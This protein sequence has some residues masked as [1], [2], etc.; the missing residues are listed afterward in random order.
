VLS[1]LDVLQRLTFVANT[2]TA[3]LPPGVTIDTVSTTIVVLDPR[4]DAITTRSGAVA[5]AL[6]S[7]PMG[8][9]PA[10]VLRAPGVSHCADWLYDRVALHR[11][12]VSGW[13]G[14]A[15]CGVPQPAHVALTAPEA[16][17]A[18]GTWMRSS[19][20]VGNLTC[21]VLMAAVWGDVVNANAAV[22]QWM[23]YRQP[24][25][26]QAVIDYPRI[27]QGWR[28]FAPHAPEEDFSIE[29]DAVTADGRHVDPYNEVASRTHMIPSTEIAARLHQNQFFTAFS[30]FIWRDHFRAYR[31][32]FQDWILRYPE[33]T[34]RPQDRIVGYTAYKLRDVSPPPRQ[35]QP[36]GFTREPFMQWGVTRGLSR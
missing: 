14:L 7:L 16:S 11:A 9:V 17:P 18:R 24:E 4:S 15:A 13:L 27:Y 25:V 32:A 6:R 26:L 22:P 23:R 34:G 21:A 33:R 10:L 1:R 12:E 31:S 20:V 30:L 19:Y 29:V 2:D 36:S 8:V 35:R 3:R 5:S 28:M